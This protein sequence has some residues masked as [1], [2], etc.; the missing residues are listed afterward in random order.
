MTAGVL[1][2]VVRSEWVKLRSLRSTVGTYLAIAVVLVALHGTFLTLPTGSG[3]DAALTALLLV[4]LLVAGV[5][6]LATGGEYSAGTARSTFTAVPRRSLVLAGKLLVHGGTVLA[7]L[8]AG[9]LVGAAVAAVAAPEATGSPLDP[10]VLHAALGALLTL[11]CVVALGLSA[12]VLTR[13]PAAGLGLVFLLLVVPVVVVTAPE[14][15]AFLPGRA[16]HGLVFP[17]DLAPAEAKLLPPEAAA[18]VLSGWA[19]G[20][21]L[22]AAT[23]L[24]RRDV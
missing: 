6:V 14:V 11:V 18:L 16:A 5:A 3:P 8:L 23:V 17:G 15:T 12:G 7:L 10:V 13:S 2:G 22:L 21:V 4:E 24:R 9:A 20:S 19:A 1:A